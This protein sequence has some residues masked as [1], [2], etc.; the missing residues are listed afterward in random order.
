MVTGAKMLRYP[1]ID[2]VSHTWGTRKAH[3]RCA[4]VRA[5]VNAG[6]RWHVCT[7][8]A[9]WRKPKV[10]WF[11]DG[12]KPILWRRRAVLAAVA[13]DMQKIHTEWV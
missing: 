3:A 7:T 4:V 12:T 9:G 13:S 1:P 8:S 2:V 10:P 6:I 5:S 11:D